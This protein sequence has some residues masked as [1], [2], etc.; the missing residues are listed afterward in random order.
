MKRLL[1]KLLSLFFG[2]LASKD[3]PKKK[4]IK[5]VKKSKFSN[6]DSPTYGHGV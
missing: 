6:P 2:W 1:F 3:K 4:G 5:N